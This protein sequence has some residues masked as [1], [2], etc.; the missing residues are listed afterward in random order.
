MIW[1]TVIANWTAAL[2]DDAALV[3]TLGGRHIYPAQAARP[4][5]VPSVEYLTTSD[6]EEENFNPIFIQVDFWARGMDQ[7]ATIEER[8]RSITHRDTAR[9]WTPD[10]LRLWTQYVDARTLPYP[11]DPGVVY[12]SMDFR[13][14]GVRSVLMRSSS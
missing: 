12:R 5:R 2:L 14:A 9:S 4:V 13:F 3:D 1:P 11:K 10:G 7:A 8:L 6:R